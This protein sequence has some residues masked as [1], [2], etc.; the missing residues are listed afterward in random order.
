MKPGHGLAREMYERLTGR[1][2][3]RLTGRR[4]RAK[5]RRKV[6]TGA[7][8]KVMAGAAICAV[9]G[10]GGWM[11]FSFV[12]GLLESAGNQAKAGRL[13]L[14]VDESL[15][16]AIAEEGVKVF[17]DGKEIPAES[18]EEELTLPPGEHELV[19][20]KGKKTIYTKKFVVPEGEEAKLQIAFTDGRV[21][22]SVEV[23]LSD[24]PLLIAD[25]PPGEVYVLGKPDKKRRGYPSRLSLSANG[26]YLVSGGTDGR[27]TLWD[28]STGAAVRTL[29]PS[30]YA[31]GFLGGP[32]WS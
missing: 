7:L 32:Q 30:R 15:R 8:R 26:R 6:A 3:D 9:I 29:Q 18:L 1:D 10:L 5:K 31:G 28:L 25:G 11:L 23:A 14:Q 20:K 4:R 21:E 12:G 22:S 2:A 17:V 13:R 16:K 19:V 27:L 24:E